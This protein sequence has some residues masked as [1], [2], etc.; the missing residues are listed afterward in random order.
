MSQDIMFMQWI[1][2]NLGILKLGFQNGRWQATAGGC[3]GY[4]KDISEAL[5]NLVLN[6]QE[7]RC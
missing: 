1:K 3:Y 5:A 2:E 6:N 7:E 4:G